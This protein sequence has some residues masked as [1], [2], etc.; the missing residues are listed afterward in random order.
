M[1]ATFI[2]SGPRL[3]SGIQIEAINAT[4]VYPLMMEV[5]GLQITS[6]IDGDPAKLLQLLK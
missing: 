2:A 5:L 3:P 4:D 6:P 1:H